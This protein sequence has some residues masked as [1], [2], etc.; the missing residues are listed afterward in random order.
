MNKILSVVLLTTLPWLVQGQSQFS[1]TGKIGTT[2]SKFIYLSYIADGRNVLDSAQL[3]NG[4]FHFK[5]TLSGPTLSYVFTRTAASSSITDTK[6]LYL[7]DG[8]VDL[9]AVDSVKNAV[10][11]GSSLQAS[12]EA[13]AK[14]F[15]QQDQILNSINTEYAAASLQKKQDTVFT[16]LL[17]QK[18]LEAADQKLAIQQQYIAEHPDSY[19][20]LVAL[21]EMANA[22]LGLADIGMMFDTLD[23]TV[24]TTPDGEEL[25]K[26]VR[27]VEITRI[28]D[29]AQDFTQNDIED[30]PVKLSDFRGKYVLIDFWASWCKPC[31]AENQHLVEA[32]NSYKKKNFTILGV[33][34]DQS[35]KRDEWLE[36]IKS[37]KLTWT[38]V[39][40][41]KF[42]KNEIALLYGVRSIPQNYLLDPQGKIIRKN[43][44]GTE[45]KKV[46][47]EL[48]P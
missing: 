10:A 41:L 48:I 20:S 39:S 13:Y 31:R 7:G 30:H 4:A 37:D 16:G 44:S 35:G 46:L 8:P 19:F 14:G 6:A 11:T 25:A 40:D 18:F 24:R 29:P 33:S 3:H 2:P 27:S 1:I 28:G 22:G 38:H 17:Q 9:Q 34:L 23:Q 47:S 36:A 26:L 42:W 5:G 15:Q 32:F 21:K 12:Y 45:L 43:L